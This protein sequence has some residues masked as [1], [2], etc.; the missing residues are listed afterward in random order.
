MKLAFFDY[1]L[2][3]T[4]LETITVPGI[5]TLAQEKSFTP[6][7]DF[8][9]EVGG[10]PFIQVVEPELSFI[11]KARKT[12]SN[13]KRESWN[14]IFVNKEPNFTP[15]IVNNTQINTIA[16]IPATNDAKYGNLIYIQLGNDYYKSLV[17]VWKNKPKQIA[18]IGDF[19]EYRVKFGKS[20]G[21]LESY[22]G[23]GIWS[24]ARPNSVIRDYTSIDKV[25]R[26]LEQPTLTPKNSRILGHY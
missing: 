20:V 25:I 10:I 8:D 17:P 5:I 23:N 3:I 15:F 24:I 1:L 4:N 19:V 13:E 7:L 2:T 12:G 26:K 11:A 6:E 16:Q 22:Q 14:M 21:W 18:G 9:L